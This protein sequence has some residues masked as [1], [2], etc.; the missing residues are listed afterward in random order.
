MTLCVI[1][2]F[3]LCVIGVT[4][5]APMAHMARTVKTTAVIVLMASVMLLPESAS[6]TPGF[7]AHS[8]LNDTS[9]IKTALFIPL[10]AVQY[11]VAKG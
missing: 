11:A 8:K 9:K 3:F 6:V 2:T 7:M 10:T 5:A 4:C 1:K